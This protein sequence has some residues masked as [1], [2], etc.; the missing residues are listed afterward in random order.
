MMNPETPAGRHIPGFDHLSTLTGGLGGLWIGGGSVYAGK[1]SLAMG[2]TAAVASP[3]FPVLYL[4]MENG[5]APEAGVHLDEWIVE[6]YGAESPA[7]DHVIGYRK[8]EDLEADRR[9]WFPAPAMIV[10]DAVQE[11]A[12][13]AEQG[14]RRAALDEKLTGTFKAL[15]LAGY[16]VVLLSQFN[17]GAYNGRPSLK[18]FKESSTIEAVADAAI[19]IWAPAESAAPRLTVLKARGKP[20]PAADILLRRA[21][22]RL[23]ESQLVPIRGGAGEQRAPKLSEVTRAV[24]KLGGEADATSL[25]RV[26]RYSRATLKRRID[27]AMVAGEL[28]RVGKGPATRLRLAQKLAHA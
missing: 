27:V 28:D 16:T 26:L 12:A 15:K 2:L 3:D 17:R 14:Q 8:L 10:V 25:Q 9:R 24:Q 20:K 22:P 11:F 7:R 6:A 4:D 19:G 18:D 5:K 13:G 21:G 1:T 23:F